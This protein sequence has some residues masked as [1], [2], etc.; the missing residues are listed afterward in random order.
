MDICLT[1][2]LISGGTA[3]IHEIL[4]SLTAFLDVTKASS[5]KETAAN[6]LITEENKQKI[7]ILQSQQSN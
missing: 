2:I 5:K 4:T 6:E 1:G 7:K 3:G